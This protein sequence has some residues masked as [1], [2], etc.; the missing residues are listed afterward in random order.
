[1]EG[2]GMR[3]DDDCQVTAAEEV[4]FVKGFKENV[5]TDGI[6]GRH[7]GQV[8]HEV[9]VVIATCWVSASLRTKVV[10]P[11]IVPVTVHTVVSGWG[12]L[13]AAVTV[14]ASPGHGGVSR[15]QSLLIM[16]QFSLPQGAN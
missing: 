1:M 14:D 8:D 15:E 2:L 12:R 11:L 5:Q 16:V 3:V 4:V 6:H 13:S 10:S 9:G 7:S